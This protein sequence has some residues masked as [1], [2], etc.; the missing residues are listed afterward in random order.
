MPAFCTRCHKRLTACLCRRD[1][2]VRRYLA[3]PGQPTTVPRELLVPRF[4]PATP[5]PGAYEQ[6]LRDGAQLMAAASFG[7]LTD[8][9]EETDECDFDRTVWRRV[10]VE[11]D[12]DGNSYKLVLRTGR[13]PSAAVAGLFG[14][15]G[16][17]SFDCGEAIQLLRWFAQLRAMG[18]TA[19][20]QKM[21][22]IG[23]FELREHDSTGLTSTRVYLRIDGDG[24]YDKSVRFRLEDL[25]DEVVATTETLLANAPIG[26]RIM[27]RNFDPC[28]DEDDAFKNENAIKLDADAFF[29]HPMGH[30]SQAAL[31]RELAQTADD[32]LSDEQADAYAARHIRIVDIEHYA[33]T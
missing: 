30:V 20:D 9:D 23:A 18:T 24:D 19:F 8:C 16:E 31:V 4:Q 28:V 33:E 10:F 14:A 11:D 5:G 29:A 17:W 1:A 15:I 7:G 3:Q 2:P 32:S 27:W 13:R 12:D 21:H 25:G 22:A 6:A 26:S